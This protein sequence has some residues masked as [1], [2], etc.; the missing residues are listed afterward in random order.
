MKTTIAIIISLGLALSGA[1]SLLATTNGP[2]VSSAES[3]PQPKRIRTEGAFRPMS[4]A[5]K[6]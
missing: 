5:P 6:Y 3:K 1:D 4:H 2:V